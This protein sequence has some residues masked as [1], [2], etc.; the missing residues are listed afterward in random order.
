MMFL[1]SPVPIL[2][3][4]ILVEAVLVIALLRT[5]RGI[6]LAPITVV[7]LIVLAGVLIERLVVT[8]RKQVAAAIAEAAAAIEADD[9]NRL[10]ACI[11]PSP[12]GDKTRALA[13]DLHTIWRVTQIRI[14]NLNVSINAYTNPRTATA[15]FTAIVTGGDRAGA[16]SDVTRPAEV[17][18]TLQLESGRWLITG[19]DI[20]RDPRE[21]P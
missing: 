10:T 17:K 13:R 20:T 5:G 8:E 15:T 19:H 14:R 11:S 4:G 6:L 9:M 7:A 2:V 16:I 21:Q 12:E 18:V 3:V 1:E